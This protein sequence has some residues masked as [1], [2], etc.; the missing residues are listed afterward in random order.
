MLLR[1][2]KLFYRNQKGGVAFAFAMGASLYL[3]FFG[4]AFM[5]NTL[6]VW[7]YKSDLNF[8][9]KEAMAIMRVENGADAQ[10]RTLFYESLEKLHINP[11]NVTFSATPKTVQRKTP[12]EVRITGQ[13]YYWSYEMLGI[14]DYKQEIPV[15]IPGIA[16]KLIR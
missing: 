7:G 12:L 8:A 1:R 2:L 15:T 16:R 9:G 3:L 13:A 5:L 4:I 6:Q 10:T 14:K 11:D